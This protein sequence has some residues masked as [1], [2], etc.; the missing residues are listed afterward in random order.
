MT[1]SITTVEKKESLELN[2]DI[3]IGQVVKS[4]SEQEEF[5]EQDS[6]TNLISYNKTNESSNNLIGIALKIQEDDQTKNKSRYKL[7]NQLKRKQTA[8][9]TKKKIKLDKEVN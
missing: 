6:K 8:E 7:N 2:N 1:K 4:Y 5:F 9:T 3:T